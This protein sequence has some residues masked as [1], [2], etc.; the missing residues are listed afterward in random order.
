MPPQ[1]KEASFSRGCDRPGGSAR[2]AR[3]AF[4]FR[5]GNRNGGAELPLKPAKESEIE[6]PHGLNV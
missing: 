6:T 3:R 1:S 4:V 5:V 2:K